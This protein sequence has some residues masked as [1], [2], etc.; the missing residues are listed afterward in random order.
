MQS[1]GKDVDAEGS[2]EDKWRGVKRE[3][4]GT[5]S[6]INGGEMGDDKQDNCAP[7]PRCPIMGNQAFNLE[8]D[9]GRLVIEEGRSRYVSNSFWA[10]LSDEVSTSMFAYL[11]QT[12]ETKG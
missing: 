12:G 11:V 3:E 7:S 4:P 6:D 9:I 10:S 2:V 8:K 5:E 1:L